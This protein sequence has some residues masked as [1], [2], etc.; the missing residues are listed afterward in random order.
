[1]SI[2][3]VETP[4]R[5]LNAQVTFN[6]GGSEFGRG[7]ESSPD[8]DKATRVSHGDVPERQLFWLVCGCA[9]FLF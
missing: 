5:T 8:L 7:T 2:R 4:V 9:V 6:T 3:N 1:M